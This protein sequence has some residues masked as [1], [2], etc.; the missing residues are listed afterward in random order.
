[1]SEREPIRVHEDPV[2]FREAINFTAAET[3]FAARL[4]E[5]DYFCTLLLTYLAGAEH[6]VFKGGTCL[7]KIHAGF[8]RLSEDLDFAVSLPV[9]AAR[10]V[11]KKHAEPLRRVVEKLPA[12]FRVI[13]PVTG[14]NNSV[15]YNGEANYTSLLDGHDEAILIEL[16]LREPLLMPAVQGA[17]RTV[18]LDPLTGMPMVPTVAVPC[19]T[20]KEAFAEKFRAA[21]SRRDV[22]IR[23]FF[24]LDHAMHKLNLVPSDGDLVAMVK[25]KLSIP[26]NEP[27]N[28]DVERLAQ[29]RGQVDGRLRSVLRA[30]DFAAFNLDRAFG[31][32]ASMADAVSR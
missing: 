10:S 28:V 18:L 9:D 19:I 1:M 7:A 4:I 6:A 5:K 11:R 21:L 15:Q 22:A 16:S 27:V 20:R 8:Y 3:G 32:V 13:T 2:L 14:H 25:Q 23:D 30:K 31:I 24:D 29:L 26:K 12:P 17:A